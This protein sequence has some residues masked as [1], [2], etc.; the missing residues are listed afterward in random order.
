M[1]TSLSYLD[2]QFPHGLIEQPNPL[3]ELEL[4]RIRRLKN[5]EEMKRYSLSLLA[6]PLL[7]GLFGC[8]C[9]QARSTIGTLLISIGGPFATVGMVIAADMYY[10]M[11]TI[12]S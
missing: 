9:I 4:R 2:R 12:S 5:V 11:L 10:T 8:L 3:F 1:D 7:F 6:I